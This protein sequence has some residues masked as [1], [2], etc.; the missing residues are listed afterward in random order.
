MLWLSL[1]RLIASPPP[2]VGRAVSLPPPPFTMALRCF[3]PQAT[4]PLRSCKDGTVQSCSKHPPEAIRT[5]C[6]S[7]H[8]GWRIG[9]RADEGE[10]GCGVGVV[11]PVIVAVLKIALNQG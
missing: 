10:R 8:M 5:L 4:L 1:S 2:T 9:D 7:P 6:A 3:G 11:L